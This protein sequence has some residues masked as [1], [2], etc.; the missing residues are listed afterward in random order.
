MRRGKSGIDGT[1]T[2]RRPWTGLACPRARGLPVARAEGRFFLRPGRYRAATFVPDLRAAPRRTQFGQR[3]HHHPGGA[4]EHPRLV[5]CA[6]RPVAALEQLFGRR[7]APHV[8]LRVQA[9]R[10]PDAGRLPFPALR[11]RPGERR[12]ALVHRR[13]RHL[14]SREV[15]RR[16]SSWCR[17]GRHH[18]HAFGLAQRLGGLGRERAARVGWLGPRR[19]GPVLEARSMAIGRCRHGCAVNGIRGLRRLSGDPGPRRPR[20]RVSCGHCRGLRSSKR[21]CRRGRAHPLG[22]WRRRRR[23]PF[24]P[25]VAARTVGPEPVGACR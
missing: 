9:V 15:D 22:L 14:R 5:G 8:E 18:L 13:Q 20:S 19:R 24:C 25:A 2:R 11:L 12:G 23:R 1:P 10:A 4:L 17:F 16:W 7:H 3:R 21:P 6:P